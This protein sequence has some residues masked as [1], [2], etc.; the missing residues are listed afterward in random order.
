MYDN[1]CQSNKE[2]NGTAAGDNKSRNVDSGFAVLIC[3]ESS[4][5]I[6]EALGKFQLISDLACDVPMFLNS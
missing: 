3:E 6:D 2:Y 1:E 5:C 4:Y